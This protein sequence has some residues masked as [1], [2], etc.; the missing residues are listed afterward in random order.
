ML[1]G[2]ARF[3]GAISGEAYIAGRAGERFAV[4]NSGATLIIEGMGDHGCEYMTNGT[5]ICLGP[6]GLNLA[7]GMSGGK[8]YVFADKKIIKRSIFSNSINITLSTDKD[9]MFIKHHIVSHVKLTQSNLANS[10]LNRW[11]D[12]KKQIFTISVIVYKLLH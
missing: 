12:I 9:L 6:V 10:I 11:N 8:I 4:R 7:A 1:V 5:V 2:N 3:Y